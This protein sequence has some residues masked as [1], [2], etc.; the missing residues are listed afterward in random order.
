MNAC[1][2]TKIEETKWNA[3]Q[4]TQIQETQMQCG[5]SYPRMLLCNGS[6]ERGAMEFLRGK[7]QM[8][9]AMHWNAAW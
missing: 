8:S 1:Q 6:L 9:E 3:C 7:M 5:S 4:K 2:K